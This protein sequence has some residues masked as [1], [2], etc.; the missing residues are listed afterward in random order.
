MALGGPPLLTSVLLQLRE[1]LGLP[2]DLMFFFTLVV[3]TAMVG[4]L[5]PALAAALLGSTLLNYFFTEPTGGLRIDEPEQALAVLLFLVV[6]VGV[7]SLVHLAERRSLEARAAEAE[8]DVL[9]ALSRAVL[10]GADTPAAVVAEVARRLGAPSA[11]LWGRDEPGAPWQVVAHHPEGA[12]PSPAPGGD[13]RALS[14]SLTLELPERVLRPTDRR[15][16][17]TFT[18]QIALVVDRARLRARADRARE[19]E[20]ATAVRTALLNAASHDLRTPLA[21][22]RTA[23][24]GLAAP[25]GVV[26]GPDESAELVTSV[27]DATTRLERLVDNLLD[28]SMLH[29]GAVGPELVDLSLDEVVPAALDGFERD[30]VVLDLPESTPLVRTDAGLLER[31]VANLVA[32][33]VRAHEGVGEPVVVRAVTGPDHVELHVVDHGAG[34]A[35]E[36]RERMFEPFQRLSGTSTGLGLGLAVARGLSTAVGARLT[37]TGTPGGGL[38]MV[39]AVPRSSTPHPDPR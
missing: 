34:V 30:R 10:A 17:D 27:A 22:I 16:L 6:A 37:A 2:T 11:V 12:R 28:L 32:N 35:D 4:G 14:P 39:V 1:V 15:V 19:L 31:V 21:V 20:Q 5:L 13:L 9:A 38:T 25:P 33:A 23:V 26:L 29:T 7:A 24:D 3:A 8:A 36:D 18:S